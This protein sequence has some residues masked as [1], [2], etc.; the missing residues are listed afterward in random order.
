MTTKMLED[1]GKKEGATADEISNTLARKMPS[2]NV[3]K[4]IH[5][6]IGE[7]LGLVSA[8]QLQSAVSLNIF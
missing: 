5:A 1:C 8:L 6:C 3:E 4:C 2:T 7:S